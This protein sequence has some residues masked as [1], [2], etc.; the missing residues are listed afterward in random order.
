MIKLYR[1]NHGKKR[2]E[3]IAS[4]ELGKVEIPA[5][6]LE[7]GQIHEK[8]YVVALNMS[9]LHV[10]PPPP[11]HVPPL[12]LQAPCQHGAV[13]QGKLSN[14]PWEREGEG[15]SFCSVQD[16]VS[17]GLHSTTWSLRRLS[18]STSLDHVQS[19]STRDKLGIGPCP[20]YSGASLQGTSWG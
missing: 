18:Q 10:C 1:E 17:R 5:L 16:P 8:W 2:K 7:S 3:K 4:T 14:K 11:H 12:S 6:I 19:L 9:P 15:Q 13:I 20:F